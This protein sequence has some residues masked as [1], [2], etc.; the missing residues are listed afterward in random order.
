MCEKNFSSALFSLQKQ[1][2]SISAK[3]I[4]YISKCFN[5][6]LSQNKGNPEGLDISLKAIT[7]HA[8]G[9]HECCSGTSWCVFQTNPES[10]YKSLPFGKPLSCE[11][12]RLALEQLFEA[13]RKQCRKLAFP[14]ST[15]GNKAFNETVS[16]K[17]PKPLHLSAS[18]NLNY[19]VASSVAQKNQGHEYLLK[20]RCIEFI[21]FIMHV[22]QF[23]QQL[24]LIII[25]LVD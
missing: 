13:Y 2:K 25:Y 23:T 5:Y 18:A 20:V 22:F 4:K 12:L 17:A 6:A 1:H 14:G 8:F 21:I 15:Q 19:R 7:N 11:S 24:V 3:V 16:S 9:N 10:R